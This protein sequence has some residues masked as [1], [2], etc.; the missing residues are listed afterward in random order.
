MNFNKINKSVRKVRIIWLVTILYVKIILDT[1]VNTAVN[2]D[3]GDSVIAYS[4]FSYRQATTLYMQFLLK[5]SA[6]CADTSGAL[7]I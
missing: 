6:F 5:V 1:D 3:A 2:I 7:N 4:A